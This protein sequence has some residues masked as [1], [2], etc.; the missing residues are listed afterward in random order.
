MLLHGI[1]EDEDNA[2]EARSTTKTKL[3]NFLIE[4]VNIENADDLQILDLHGIPQHPL[5]RNNAKVN[6]PFIFSNLQATMT[7]DWL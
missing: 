4:G 7:N 2:W 5:H 1:G 6:R 3:K